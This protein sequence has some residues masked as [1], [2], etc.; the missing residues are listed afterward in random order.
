M[1]FI[2]SKSKKTAAILSYINQALSTVVAIFLTPILLK[3]LGVDEYGL[4]QMV[5]SVGHYIMI[6]D[7]GIGTVM[8][9]Y[10]S[11]YQARND[12][13]GEEN[14]AA[15]IG[16]FTVFV[17]VLVFASGEILNVNIENI[18]QNLTSS[19]YV[20][21]H[22]MF[23]LMVV[24]FMLSVIDHYFVGIIGA[25]ERFVFLKITGLIKLTVSFGA[26]IL[27]VMLGFGAVG[28]VLSNTIVIV[29]VTMINVWYVFKQLRFRIHYHKWDFVIVKPAIGLM[30]AMLLQSVVGYVNSSADK[31][32]LGIMCKKADVTVYSIAASIITLFNTLPTVISS[33]FQPQVTRMVVNGASK[34][35][36]TN[37]VIRVGRWQFV[38]CGL[39][40]FGL[41][42][43]GI[44]FLHLWVGHRLTHDQ[45]VFTWIIM[46]VILPFNMVPLVQTVCISILNAYDKRLYRSLILAGMCVIN[47]IVS[48][49]LVKLFGPIGCPIGTAMSFL[50]GYAIILNVYYSKGLQ[51]EVGRMFKEI[52]SK[53]WICLL[54]AAAV[55][56]PL[57]LWKHYTICY[58]LLKA[59]IF[60]VVFLL[61]M[62]WFG[63]NEEEKKICT[64]VLR[65][66]HLIN[67]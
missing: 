11:E 8:V 67:K 46:M 38:M 10:I 22:Q 7:L 37:L 29:L 30:L 62:W 66:M 20:K 15:L 6:L 2:H 14:F 32:I 63:F 5:Y 36:L 21:S 47:I 53:T 58:F 64:P 26:N 17:A 45:Q 52:V 19:D 65:K 39:L 33:L 4:Y 56:S 42:F 1:S 54:L 49:A 25:H 3:Y 24:Q 50:I 61:L 16:I 12:K 44:D 31:T 27:F 41:A 18:F 43:F 13:E 55:V 9:R 40:L 23:N 60:S 28:I 51:L 48:V 57:L 59:G 35:E 34:S